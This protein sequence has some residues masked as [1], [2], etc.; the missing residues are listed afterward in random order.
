LALDR[1][2][3]TGS[4]ILGLPFVRVGGESALRFDIPSL[5]LYF[6]GSVIWISEATFSCSF[7]PLLHRR[8]AFYHALRPHL[9]RLDVPPDGAFI[10]YTDH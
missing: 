8:F 1:G 6:F 7:S 3:C 2:L 9:V 5:K 10:F 4:F